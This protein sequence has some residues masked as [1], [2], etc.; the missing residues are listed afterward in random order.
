MIVILFFSFW[1]TM[2][3]P[4]LKVMNFSSVMMGGTIVFACVYYGIWGRKMYT[5]PVI[6]V[7]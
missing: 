4:S 5:G 2:M 7:S 3:N 1:P 6:E